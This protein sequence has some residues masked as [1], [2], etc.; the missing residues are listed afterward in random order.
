MANITALIAARQSFG[1]EPG[2]AGAVYCSDQTHSSITRGVRAMGADHLRVL[3]TGDDLKLRPDAL[4]DAIAA[5]RAAGIEPRV[6]VATA[7]TTNTGAIDPLNELADLCA[8]E[9]LWLHV[10]GAYGAP[11]ALTVAGRA[12][13][14]GLERADSIVADPHKWLFQPY[15][16]ACLFVTRPGA[17]EHAFAM[18][19]EYLQSLGDDEVNLRNR[20]LELSRR[21]RGIKLW[22]TYRAYG[23]AVLAQAVERGV[24]LAEY[25]QEAI[26]ADPRW[27]LATPAQLGIVTFDRLG[28]SPAQLERSAARVT[29]SGYAAVATTTL[30]GRTVLRLCTINPATTPDDL[31]G[32]LNRLADALDDEMGPA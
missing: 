13:L 28:A 1:P 5:D 12:Q 18:N 8:A 3:P 29:E 17:L 32:T 6:V 30:H 16:I 27:R 14:A 10:D 9:G 22:L 25:A 26:E 7:G 20:S 15:D 31:D 11:V 21:G 24:A 4:R 19:P 23:A 2:D